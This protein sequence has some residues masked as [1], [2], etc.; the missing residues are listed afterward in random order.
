LL[1]DVQQVLPLPE[2]HD[3]QIRVREKREERR[4]RS[5]ESTSRD[6]TKFDVWTGDERHARLAKRAAMKTAVKHVC[7]AGHAPE[8]LD[9]V[10]PRSPYRNWFVVEG[11]LDSEQ[12]LVAARAVAE[13][14]GRPFRAGRWYTDDDELIR[15]KG[16]TYALSC[17]WGR[18]TEDTLQALVD[19][20]PGCGLTFARS[21]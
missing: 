15:S 1:I 5:S 2:A 12:F 19:A 11:E 8:D 13:A 9:A 21:E 6:Y 3:Y 7:D 14:G 10:L 20:F 4:V 18:K 17:Q 16:K